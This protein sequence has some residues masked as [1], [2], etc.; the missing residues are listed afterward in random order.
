[1]IR[2]YLK[3]NIVVHQVDTSFEN[4]WTADSG[5]FDLFIM[6]NIILG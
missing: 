3:F 1:M 4:R 2:P 5:N 6:D